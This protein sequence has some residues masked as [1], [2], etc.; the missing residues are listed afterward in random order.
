[1]A[2]TPKLA[3][4]E[5]TASQSGKY[6]THNAGL[7]ILDAFVFCSAKDRTNTPPGAPSEGDVYL[8][9]AV[10]A[11]DWAGHEDDL[12]QYYNS[13]WA[14]Y[15]PSA[16]WVCWVDD[17]AE[18][19]RFSAAWEK[20]FGTVI[21]DEITATIANITNLHTTYN[22]LDHTPASDQTGNGDII[23]DTVDEN[24]VGFGG[25]LCLF[26]NGNWVDAD[27]VEESN[28]DAQMPCLVLALEA[29]TGASKKLLVR[30]FA[31]DDSWTWNVGGEAGKIYVGES[32]ALTQAQPATTGDRIQVVAY[33]KSSTVIFFNPDNTIIEYVE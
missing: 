1:M 19:Y 30:G 12:T 5:I 10:A 32:G 24:T 3:L 18:Y 26:S 15:T 13:A 6:I 17:E 33:A 4:P 21:F 23:E 31:R 7:Q 27:H 22:I 29:G 16:G 28:G 20:L 8:I 9:T 14:F 25:A 11:G 2:N